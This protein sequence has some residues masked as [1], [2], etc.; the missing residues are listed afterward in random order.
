MSLLIYLIMTVIVAIIIIITGLYNILQCIKYTLM[1]IISIY[2][3]NHL[4]K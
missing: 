3:Y 4:V 2:L 1:H